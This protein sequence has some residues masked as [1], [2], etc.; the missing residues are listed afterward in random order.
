MIDSH[1]NKGLA[2]IYKY[3][4]YCLFVFFLLQYFLFRQFIY[5]EIIPV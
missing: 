3:K 2:F 4:Y 1:L 5:R